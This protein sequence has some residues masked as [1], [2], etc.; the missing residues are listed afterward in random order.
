MTKDNK[1]I[2]IIVP[3]YR[4]EKTIVENIKGIKETM[5]KTSYEYEIIVVVDGM[6]HDKTFVNAK[7]LEGSKIKVISYE[8]NHGK[9]YA[10]RFGMAKAKGNLIA[11]MDAG[12]DLNPNG[13]PLLIENLDWNDADIVV[14]SKLHPDSKVVYPASR[15]ILSFFSQIWIWMLFGLKVR[16]TQTGMKIFKREV[17]EKVMPRLLIKKFAFDVEMLAVAGHLGYTKKY[18]SPVE[19]NYN[20]ESSIMTKSFLW[21]LFQTLVDTLAIY[22]R[23]NILHYYD[24]KNQRKWRFDP[25]LNFNINI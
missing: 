17:L 10:V 12:G 4:Q 15:R 3:T 23:L 25:E 16:D 11:F 7:K 22:Y 5:D 9:G 19:L 2:S 20:F 13:L 14:G 24:D 8:H 1:Y 21:V 6:D 18:E